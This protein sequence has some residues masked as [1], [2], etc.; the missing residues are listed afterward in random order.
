VS[1]QA[2]APGEFPPGQRLAGYRLEEIIGRGGMAVVYRAYDERLGR[3]VALKVLSPRYA[4]DEAFRQRFMRESRIAASVDHPNIIPVFEAGETGGVLFIAMRFVEGR[5]VLTIIEQQGPLPAARVCHIVT[6]AAAALDAA[7]RRGLVHRDV[8][9]ANMLRDDAGGESHPDH[10]YLSDFGLSKRSLSA[11]RL[12][13]H[14]EFL[15]TMGYV[16]P[17]QIEGRPVD[18]RTDQYALACSAFEMLTGAPPFNLDETM[19]VMWAQVSSEP[20]ALTSRR[21][22][23]PAAVDQVMARALAKAPGDRYGSCLEFAAALSQACAPPAA[24]RPPPRRH[25]PTQAVNIPDLG[26]ADGPPEGAPP[27]PGEPSSREPSHGEPFSREPEPVTRWPGDSEPPTRV[28]PGAPPPAWPQRSYEPTAAIGPLPPAPAPTGPGSGSAGPGRGSAGPGRG[29]AGPGGPGGGPGWPAAPAGYGGSP[30]GHGGAP[31]YGGVPDYGGAS[32]YG[33]APAVRAARRSW[34]PAAIVL[35]ACVVVLGAAGGA[36]AL[37]GGGSGATAT[38]A[39]PACTT[40]TAPA[41]P[42]KAHGHLVATGGKPFDVV[43]APGG[44]AFVSLGD[45]VAVM[46]TTGSAA[47]LVRRVPVTEALGEALTH[48]QKYLLVTGQGGLTV[49]RVSDLEQGATTPAGALN[50]PGGHHAVQVAV[51]PDGHFAFVTLQG[52]ARVAV[53]NLHRALTSGFGPADLVGQIPVGEQPVGIAASPDGRYLYVASGL[54]TPATTSGTGYLTVVDLPKAETTPSS[55]VLKAVSAGCGPDR[56]A[57]SADGQD[58]WVTVGGGNAVVAYAAGKLLTD[59]HHALIAKVGVG[60]T[61]LGLVLASNGSRLVVA[62][63]N[64]DHVPGGVSS[65][66]VV[67]T[68]QALAGQHALLGAV[69]S[70]DVPRALALIPGGKT[71]LVADTGSGQVQTVKLSHLP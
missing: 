4:Q 67:N 40:K 25:E 6:Q 29:S 12:T 57:V 68:A 44:Y 54:A 31:G 51:S 30:P 56:V 27:P 26:A 21:P 62:D 16:A 61:P 35:A 49:F 10:V 71:L 70:G 69:R 32:G 52:N 60:Q 47:T 2:P 13:S 15:G 3:S 18:G 66:A 38:I 41:T 37:L 33:G 20:P 9:P 50:S 58:V 43:A 42:L 46:R 64:R 63:S 7:H 59:P 8:K 19:A 5:D 14:G 28:P 34:R 45:A 65:L 55:A 39:P 23:L 11:T 48:D 36:Y 24:D 1:D 17:E 22:D 53:F